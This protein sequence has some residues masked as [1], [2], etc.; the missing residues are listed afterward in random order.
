MHSVKS[1]V[2]GLLLL[3]CLGSQRTGEPEGTPWFSGKSKATAFQISGFIYKS[4]TEAYFAV[5]S[6]SFAL[7]HGLGL[8]RSIRNSLSKH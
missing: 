4:R 1:P 2:A 7:S 5:K 8:G 6:L 3:D